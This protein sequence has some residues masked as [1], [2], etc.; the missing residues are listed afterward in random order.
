[1]MCEEHNAIY[2]CPRCE[3]KT[4]SLPCARRHRKEFDCNGIRDRA[5][6]IPVK[7]FTNMDL[8]SG[9]CETLHNIFL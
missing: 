9:K 6:Y 1:M 5:K 3:R 8:L 2:T 4:C 7:E